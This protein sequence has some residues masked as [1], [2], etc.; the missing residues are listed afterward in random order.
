MPVTNIAKQ[1]ALRA[2]AIVLN[3]PSSFDALCFRQ[4]LMF[5]PDG[6]QTDTIAGI[7]VLST[8]DTADIDYEPLGVAKVLFVDPWQSS[9][10]INSNDSIFA[11][12]GRVKSMALIES[13]EGT[14]SLEKNDIL[15]LRISDEEE[16]G[17]CYEVI[18]IQ[19]PIG[20]PS[21]LNARRYVLNKRD[22]LDY[23]GSGE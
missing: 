1:T 20:I 21:P 17:L 18:D 7:P 6:D 3:H 22:E 15:Y 11:D 19:N 23:L 4:K 2:R 14:F 8:E 5:D 13:D 12:D 9:N 10:V 16:L